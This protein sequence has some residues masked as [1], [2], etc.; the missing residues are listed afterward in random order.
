[1]RPLPDTQEGLRQIPQ[2]RQRQD[3]LDDQLKDLH[4]AANRLGC[5]DAADYLKQVIKRK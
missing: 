4:Q 2:C 1:M 5:Y 3:S